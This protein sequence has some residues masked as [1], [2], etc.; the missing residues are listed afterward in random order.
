MASA[1]SHRC[2]SGFSMPSSKTNIRAGWAAWG[3]VCRLPR[4]WLTCT[5]EA[6]PAAARA[7]AVDQ[8]MTEL[9]QRKGIK[10]MA[11]SGCGQDEDIK[12]SREA[13]FEMHLIKPVSLQILRDTIRRVIAA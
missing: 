6:S 2:S 7:C 13:G 8:I 3:W 11:V 12:R 10:G 4:R 9:K 5:G 1:L